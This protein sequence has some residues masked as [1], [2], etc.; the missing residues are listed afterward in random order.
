MGFEQLMQLTLGCS[1]EELSKTFTIGQNRWFSLVGSSWGD[2]RVTH[3]KQ[4]RVIPLG[5]A[6]V[7]AWKF[8]TNV[9]TAHQHYL[10]VRKD[11]YGH[12]VVCD[13]GHM[14]DE[15]RT[16][17]KQECDT[18]HSAWCAGYVELVDGWPRLIPARD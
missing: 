1:L 2:W 17:Y 11:R 8:D 3:P 7:L 14:Q 18:T 12:Y 16:G 9:L 13:G 6:E 10:G 15:E 4:I 5:L